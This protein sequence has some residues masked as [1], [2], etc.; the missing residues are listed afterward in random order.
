LDPKEGNRMSWYTI[1]NAATDDRHA[2]ILIY[3]EIAGGPWAEFLGLV[4]AK[5]FVKDL[6]ALDVDRITLR[7]NSPGGDVYDGVAIFNALVDHPAKVT[8]KVDGLAASIASVI[9]LAGDE[10]MIGTGAEV[11][12]HNPWTFAMGEAADLRKTAQRLE[13][14]RES[15]LDV[16]EQRT[17]MSR[18]DAAQFMD[19]ETWFRASDALEHGFAT[20]LEDE[21]E[22]AAVKNI[23]RFDERV[24]A[25]MQF[26]HVPE[27]VAAALRTPLAPLP[28]DGPAPT[29]PDVVVPADSSAGVTVPND[30]DSD[31]HTR[32]V[33][34][35]LT[36]R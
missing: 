10:R 4:S 32:R 14:I 24:A 1:R 35:L 25:R 21:P 36:A 26:R 19:E 7:V 31:A 5:Q 30:M 8:V 2:E 9:M 20:A 18:D 13:E 22:E 6:Q 16:Y 23:A 17:T 15:I 34:E 29:T 28:A 33:R 3:D 27:R 11:M 12:V